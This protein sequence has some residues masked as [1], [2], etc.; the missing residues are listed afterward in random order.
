M[1][2]YKSFGEILS[3]RNYWE[4]WLIEKAE[5]RKGA[6]CL[7]PGIAGNSAGVPS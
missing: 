2:L 6:A 7:A 5:F 4:K 3:H 1:I